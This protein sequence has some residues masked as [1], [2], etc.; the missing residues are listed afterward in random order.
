[1]SSSSILLYIALSRT[2]R[3]A[4]GDSRTRISA[5]P[6]SHR[7]LRFNFG[8]DPEMPPAHLAR[9]LDCPAHWIAPHTCSGLEGVNPNHI[10]WR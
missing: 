5:P 4:S 6:F 8:A 1:M 3:E 7:F 9:T 10:F 2:A